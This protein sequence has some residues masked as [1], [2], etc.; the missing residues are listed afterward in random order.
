[1]L[2][3]G[4]PRFIAASAVLLTVLLCIYYVSFSAAPGLE[5]LTEAK[6]DALR[7][8]TN[9]VQEM[10]QEPRLRQEPPQVTP[11]PEAYSVVSSETCGLTYMAEADVDTVEQF[12]KFDFQVCFI[13][14]VLVIV[15][16]VFPN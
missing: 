7:Q 15:Y 1:M 14:T 16:V 12:Q 2:R 9:E 10:P 6:R 8:E 4:P 5:V 13:V 3:R 11:E